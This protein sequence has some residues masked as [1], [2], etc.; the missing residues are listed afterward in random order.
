MGYTGQPNVDINFF[1]QEDPAVFY[2]AG[3]LAADG[4]LHQTKK[5]NSLSNNI[6]LSL[7]EQD[8]H[9]LEKIAKLIGYK[10][11]IYKRLV[12]NSLRNPTYKDTITYTIGFDNKIVFNDLKNRFNLTPKKSLDYR[13][14]D[15]ILNHKNINYFLLGYFDGD[16]S[17]SIDKIGRKI[18]QARMHIRG[19]V[20]F[21][22]QYNAILYDKCS[23]ATKDKI[24]S[25]DSNI[26]SLQYT[27]NKNIIKIMSFLYDKPIIYLDRKYDRFKQID[28]INRNYSCLTT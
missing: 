20:D 25:T 17:L 15:W 14:P 10:N 19:T 7:K 22:T 8:L 18:P 3:F 2:V 5:G 24:I 1:K 13:F 11:K 9:H 26:G 27:G 4:W 12:K 16:G 6:G 21:L 28:L 23:L